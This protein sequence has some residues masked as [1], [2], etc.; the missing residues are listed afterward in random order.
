MDGRGDK[1]PVVPKLRVV[2]I[3][4]K[5]LP[6]NRFLETLTKVEGSEEVKPCY[7]RSHIGVHCDNRVGHT[8]DFSFS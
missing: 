2:M 8:L 3:G 6:V 5:S 7:S 4:C 1:F